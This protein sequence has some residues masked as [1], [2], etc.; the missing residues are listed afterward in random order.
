LNGDE[1][2][3]PG[4]GKDNTMETAQGFSLIYSQKRMEDNTITSRGPL[5]WS[6]VVGLRNCG[7]KRQSVLDV[8]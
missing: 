4:T 5:H 8:D 7:G 2:V 3:P 6:I 1:N